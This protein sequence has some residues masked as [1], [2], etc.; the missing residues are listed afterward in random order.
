MMR[1]RHRQ[2]GTTLL[3]LI[4]VSTLFAAMS[5]FIFSAGTTFSEVLTEQRGRSATFTN[6]NV[7]RMRLLGDADSSSSV[8]CAAADRLQFTVGGIPA[9]LVEYYI[10]SGELV[11]WTLP[12]DHESLVAANA[13]ALTCSDLGSDGIAVGID[14][15]GT[16][17]PYH[18]HFRVSESGS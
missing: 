12:P 8:A 6:G 2:R 17:H 11:R 18:L 10:R 4:V 1:E 7:T 14:M 5:T 16:I 3:E 13:S 9:T 15:G